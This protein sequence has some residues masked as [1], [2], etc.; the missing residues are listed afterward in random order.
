M[1][2]TEGLRGGFLRRT[3]AAGLVAATLSVGLTGIVSSTTA[4]A[5][6][7]A[8]TTAIF[9]E[10]AQAPPTTSSRS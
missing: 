2:S 7:G 5:A 6:P 10:Q 1:G 9:A 8:K 4:S 3:L